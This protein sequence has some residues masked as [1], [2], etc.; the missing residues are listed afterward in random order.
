M[1]EIIVSS[2]VQITQRSLF[3]SLSQAQCMDQMFHGE[4]VSQQTV[5]SQFAIWTVERCDFIILVDTL[6]CSMLAQT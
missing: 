1:K 2:D 4:N 6:T 3:R 5:T